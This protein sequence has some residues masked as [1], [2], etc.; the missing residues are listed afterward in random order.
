MERSPDFLRHVLSSTPDVVYVFDMVSNKNIYTNKEAE[1]LLGYTDQ[2]VQ[3]FGD[4][5]LDQLL[6]PEDLTRYFDEHLP[7]L[8]QLADGEVAEF[9]Y[10]MKTKAGHYKWFHS[11]DVIMRRS[12]T[13]EPTLRLGHTQDINKQMKAQEEQRILGRFFD[14]SDDLFLVID[15]D[16]CIQ[17]ANP[18]ALRLL[19]MPKLEL[20]GR[21]FRSIIHPDDRKKIGSLIKRS[22]AAAAAAPL[23]SR[24]E[25]GRIINWRTTYDAENGAQYVVGIDVTQEREAE[26]A[27]LV[28]DRK[29]EEQEEHLQLLADNMTD[30]VCLHQPSGEYVYLGPSAKSM[31]GYTP[32]ELIGQNPYEYFHPDDIPHVLAD[33][34]QPLLDSQPDRR[35]VRETEYRFRRKDGRYVWLHSTSSTVVENGEIKAIVSS[36]RDV[37]ERKQHQIASDQYQTQLKRSNEELANFAYIASHDLQEPLRM[38]SSYLQLLEARYGEQLDQDAQDFIEFAVNGAER[39]KRLIN[40]LLDYSRVERRFAQQQLIDLNEVVECATKNLS[41]LLQNHQVEL[42]CNVLPK[43][44]AND[45]LMIQVFQNLISNS[46]KFRAEGNVLIDIKVKETDEFWQ[47]SVQDNG[48]GIEEKYHAKIFAIFRKLN[49]GI[50]G[51]GIGLAVIKKVVDLHGGRVWIESTLGQG[52]TVFFTIPKMQNDQDELYTEEKISPTSRG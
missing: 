40:A 27:K 42:Q 41:V 31:T 26:R 24:L 7:R 43:I 11:R 25:S 3:N 48:I 39:M 20:M 5:L 36:S 35:Q 47:F 1:H 16:C 22:E 13:G 33:S 15:Q 49:A 18:A 12:P 46:V 30:M 45:T 32:E 8:N 50:E 21:H 19:G 44:Y 6:H 51:T 37:T 17:R 52:T 4:Q 34:H 14:H 23:E 38:I 2:E 28:A 10:R 29:L 9:E